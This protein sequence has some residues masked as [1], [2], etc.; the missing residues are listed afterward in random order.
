MT[1]GCTR[2]HPCGG[3]LRLDR[4]HEARRAQFPDS[5]R[6]SP[7]MRRCL[8][9]HTFLDVATIPR[10][11]LRPTCG[12]CDQPVTDRGRTGKPLV[13]H[14]ACAA[15]LKQSPKLRVHPHRWVEVAV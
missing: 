1:D 15:I 4:E 9:G 10:V 7:S 14:V 6:A 3:V 5:A 11:V 8:N 2:D 13:N 12:L